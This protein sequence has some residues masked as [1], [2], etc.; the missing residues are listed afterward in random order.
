LEVHS[1]GQ[2]R[3]RLWKEFRKVFPS[4]ATRCEILDGGDEMVQSQFDKRLVRLLKLGKS[5][6]EA[7]LELRAMDFQ[8]YARL[9]DLFHRMI[10]R[11]RLTSQII[12]GFSDSVDPH[13]VTPIDTPDGM[14][15]RYRILR[16]ATPKENSDVE[17]PQEAVDPRSALK[18]ALS[19][20]NWNRAFLLA[21]RILELYPEDRDGRE[22]RQIAAAQLNNAEQQTPKSALQQGAVPRLNVPDHT[23]AKS[24]LTSKERYVLSRMDGSRTLAEIASVIPLQENDF[25]RIVDAFVRRGIVGVS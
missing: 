4:D 22:A 18:I 6:G 15:R 2:A 24:H 13:F 7:G 23:L 12:E 19:G 11:P 5:L 8:L 3:G 17:I 1:E 25:Y 16:A 10:L 20:R 14:A 9:Y 21:E